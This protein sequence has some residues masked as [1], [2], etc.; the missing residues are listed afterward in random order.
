[1]TDI[2]QKL[3]ISEICSIKFRTNW[4]WSLPGLSHKT[5]FFLQIYLDGID[6]IK[7]QK[8]K[9]L[10]F[11]KFLQQSFHL[12]LNPEGIK[13]NKLSFKTWYTFNALPFRWI[14]VLNTCLFHN[15]GPIPM[16][17]INKKLNSRLEQTVFPMYSWSE[18]QK[19]Y[20]H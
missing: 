16:F 2:V 12:S 9:I 17:Y 10:S 13:S 18:S 20:F 5:Y 7:E 19:L 3:E 4:C 6:N 8:K 14:Q 11:S 1:M 15:K